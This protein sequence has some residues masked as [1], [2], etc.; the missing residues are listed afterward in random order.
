MKIIKKLK[1]VLL[2]ILI[3]V[4][5]ILI[6]ENFIHLYISKSIFYS[7]LIS[8]VILSVFARFIAPL[9]K[10]KVHCYLIAL[11]IGLLL[12]PYLSLMKGYSNMFAKDQAG[13]TA[14][15]VRFKIVKFECRKE[16]T[17]VWDI[18]MENRQATL[19]PGE[20]WVWLGRIDFNAPGHDRI[21]AITEIA[22]DVIWDQNIISQEHPDWG[23]PAPGQ[24]PDCIKSED[25]GGGK[26]LITFFHRDEQEGP[27]LAPKGL[28][29]RPKLP[30]NIQPDLGLDIVVGEDGRFLRNTF[31]ALFP[32]P[33]GD[34]SVEIPPPE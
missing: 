18:V 21:R 15:E 7:I 3:A 17:D 6:N 31:H 32:E 12:I 22:T 9:R 27:V 16:G 2:V 34:M 13:I 20:N 33:W 19:H 23:V 28:E 25:L 24:V 8:G 4:I 14:K 10:Y 11:T 29:K 5:G 1:W 26:Y 30:I